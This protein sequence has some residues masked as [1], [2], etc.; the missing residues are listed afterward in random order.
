MLLT[1]LHDKQQAVGNVNGFCFAN[2][3]SYADKDDLAL[4]SDHVE[5]LNRL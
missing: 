2:L 4:R 5:L 1:T 3:Q